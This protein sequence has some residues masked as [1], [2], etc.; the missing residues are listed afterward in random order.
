VDSVLDNTQERRAFSNDEESFEI[1]TVQESQLFTYITDEKRICAGTRKQAD[2]AYSQSLP[3]F[4][5]F[6]DGQI[7]VS[8][9]ASVGKDDFEKAW[10]GPHR[11]T[12][13]I[14]GCVD[15]TFAD[16]PKKHGQTG[17]AYVLTK[18]PVGGIRKDG[19]D[20]DDGD[21]LSDKILVRQVGFGRY[22][23]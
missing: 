4:F 12:F 20:P 18:P 16:D 3:G 5:F 23:Q 8:G 2:D 15:Y 1:H 19:F 21:I 13:T 6:P 17:F 11:V 14:I 22:I 10:L 7:A 9:G